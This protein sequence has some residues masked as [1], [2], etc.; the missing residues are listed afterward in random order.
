[1]TLEWRA[2]PIGSF[3]YRKKVIN[4]GG[5][6]LP[7]LSVTKD[8]GVILQSEKYNKRVATDPKKYVIVEDGDFAFD[9][10]SLYYGALGRVRGIKQGLISPDYVAFTIDGSVDADF[11]EYLLRSP[12][13]VSR[14]EKVAQQGNQFGKR[15]RVYWSVLQEQVVLLPPLE[16]QRRIAAIL[17]SVDNAINKTAAVTAQL[18]VVKKALMSELLKVNAE[19][20][21]ISAVARTFSGGTPAR[22]RKDYFGGSIPWV[23]SGE[24]NQPLIRST[25]ETLTELGIEES[26]ARIAPAG[27]VLVAMYGATAGKI[28]RLEIAAA[29]NQAI[30][31]VIPD[32]TRVLP[33]YL[34]WALTAST[35]ALLKR[36]QGSGQP[37]L[38]GELI[39]G[40][41]VPLPSLPVQARSEKALASV[42]AAVS[43]C[44]AHTAQLHAVKNSLLHD[45]LRGRVPRETTA[46]P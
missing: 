31:A 27:A 43:A 36:T 11:L 22:N 39:R 4:E 9:P 10:M 12:P 6:D 8:R 5:T 41:E 29:I 15:R 24:C 7:P 44:G 2:R 37:N 18:E 16:E 25:E 42:Q 45:L 46:D 1:M 20:I 13:M 26:S 3:A 30:L 38:S 40:L 32:E 19:M 34:F 33:G 23:K 21:K 14:Y 17:A 35:S 28:A